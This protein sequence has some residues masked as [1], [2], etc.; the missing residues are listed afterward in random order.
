MQSREKTAWRR[1]LSR[2]GKKIENRLARIERGDEGE[3]RFSGDLGS[4]AEERER[5]IFRNAMTDD[6]DPLRSSFRRTAEAAEYVLLGE[7]DT[8][9]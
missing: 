5:S 3:G 4:L 1:S 6:M 7:E 9:E 2:D 8:R